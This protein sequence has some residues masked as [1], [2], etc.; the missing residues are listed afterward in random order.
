MHGE[1]GEPDGSKPPGSGDA[2]EAVRLEPL[3]TV[4]LNE[5][6][7]CNDFVCS[8]SKGVTGFFSKERHTLVPQNLRRVLIGFMGKQHGKGHKR[9]SL[10]VDAAR[11]VHRNPDIPAWGL[12]LDV[13]G[14]PYNEKLWA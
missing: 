9:S 3:R 7:R 14:G 10:I 8:E 11:R 12:M 4:Q 1:T 5:H 13:E 6:H 2:P